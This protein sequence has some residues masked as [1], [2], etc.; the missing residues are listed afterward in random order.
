MVAAVL[1]LE[2]EEISGQTAHGVK[3]D[4]GDGSGE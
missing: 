4:Q 3:N 1:T 2:P